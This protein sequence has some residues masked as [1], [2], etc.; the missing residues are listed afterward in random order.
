MEIIG[1]YR[2]HSYFV[3]FFTCMYM[4]FFLLALYS[5]YKSFVYVSSSIA[6]FTCFLF[7]PLSFIQDEPRKRA[8]PASTH[9]ASSWSKGMV[10]ST[11]NSSLD[12]DRYTGTGTADPDG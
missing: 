11:R 8:A 2:L 7:A 12:V 3:M 9:R 6:Q 5:F 4:C 1:L 10:K